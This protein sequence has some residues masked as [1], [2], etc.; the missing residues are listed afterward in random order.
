MSFHLKS[1]SHQLRETNLTMFVYY[2]SIITEICL[3]RMYK[4]TIYIYILGDV[5][6]NYVVQLHMSQYFGLSTNT[7]KIRCSYGQLFC[8]ICIT[9]YSTFDVCNVIW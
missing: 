9:T 1:S 3:Y 2:I 7:I 6:F 5:C 4:S 8:V